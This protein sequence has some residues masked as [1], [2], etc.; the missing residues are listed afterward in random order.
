MFVAYNIYFKHKICDCCDRYT[1]VAKTCRTDCG[2]RSLLFASQL[3][4]KF[5]E[6]YS[7]CEKRKIDGVQLRDFMRLKLPDSQI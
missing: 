1:I 3:L 5:I 6:R 2:E 7:A 4:L